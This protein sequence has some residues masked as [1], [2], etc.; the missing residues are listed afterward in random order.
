MNRSL[1]QK[2]ASR[3]AAIQCLYQWELMGRKET[4][5]TVVAKHINHLESA[6]ETDKALR[7][8][9]PPH[10]GLLTD[11][12]LGATRNHAE[13]ESIL[14]THLLEDWSLPRMDRV[15]V[16]LLLAA[17]FE[18]R[19]GKLAIPPLIDEYVTLARGF[20]ATDEEAGFVNAMLDKMAKAVRGQ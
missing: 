11:I 4:G 5:E 7:A 19:Y 3:L 20:V 6:A 17:T 18:L 15:T 9:P 13:L 14:N 2:R 12:V 8:D 1:R 16:A 10:K